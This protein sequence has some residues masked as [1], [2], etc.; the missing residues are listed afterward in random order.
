MKKRII[1]AL[2]ALF[3]VNQAVLCA[4]TWQDWFSNQLKRTGLSSDSLY[5][6]STPTKI[7]LSLGS[8]TVLIAGYFLWQRQSTPPTSPAQPTQPTQLPTLT[9][10]TNSS[11]PSQG[12]PALQ[13]G[14]RYYIAFKPD[15]TDRMTIGARQCVIKKNL[16]SMHNKIK[17]YHQPDQLH[18]T[19]AF[20]GQVSSQKQLDRII[21]KVRN[22]IKSDDFKTEINRMNTQHPIIFDRYEVMGSQKKSLAITTTKTPPALMN[23]QKLL[24]MAIE[25][26]G[27]QPDIREIKPHITIGMIKDG[28]TISEAEIN[29][30]KQPMEL[31]FS[32]DDLYLEG[33][34]KP[35]KLSEPIDQQPPTEPQ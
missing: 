24:F 27:H 22:V 35:I 12:K 26:A 20:I 13:Q 10:T 30:S 17:S 4:P 1:I 31:L 9:T 21:E 29:N 2:I 3:S 6:M 11:L 32:I 7:G 8:L 14:P 16:S 23:V 28:E 34:K 25:N 18:M 19:L 15:Q 33:G 5:G